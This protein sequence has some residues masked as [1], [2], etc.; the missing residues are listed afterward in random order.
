MGDSV[1][2]TGYYNDSELHLHVSEIK[3]IE[4][5]QKNAIKLGLIG[6]AA[7]AAWGYFGTPDE[8]DDP[9]AQPGYWAVILGGL[10]GGVGY[11]LGLKCHNIVE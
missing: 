1:L 5:Y 8:P 9:L 3:K 4:I 2:A 6:A 7:G 11:A 10:G